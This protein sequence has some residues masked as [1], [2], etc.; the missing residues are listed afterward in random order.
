MKH[1]WEQKN[2]SFMPNFLHVG[3]TIVA[4]FVQPADWQVPTTSPLMGLTRKC[5]STTDG[6]EYALASSDSD[7]CDKTTLG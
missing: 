4:G 1:S 2:E 7:V 6:R 5:Q 3:Q